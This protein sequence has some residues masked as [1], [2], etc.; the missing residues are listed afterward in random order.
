MNKIEEIIIP[1]KEKSSGTIES[2]C[3][4]ITIARIK[5][6]NTEIVIPSDNIIAFNGSDLVIVPAINPPINGPIGPVKKWIIGGKIDIKGIKDP[7]I[8]ACK[9]LNIEQL[10]NSKI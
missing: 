1:P 4:K 10:Y 7:M 3:P 8:I 9:N 5:Y 6:I 2:D